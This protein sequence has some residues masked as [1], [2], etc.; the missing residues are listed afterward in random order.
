MVNRY[1]PIIINRLINSVKGIRV[2][3]QYRT[4]AMANQEMVR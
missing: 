4:E 1:N 3:V 2:S